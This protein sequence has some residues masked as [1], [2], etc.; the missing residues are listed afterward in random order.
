MTSPPVTRLVGY[1]GADVDEVAAR[2]LAMGID[3]TSSGFVFAYRR[4]AAPWGGSAFTARQVRTGMDPIVTVE[5]QLL[6]MIGSWYRVLELYCEVTIGY[7][8]R[9]TATSGAWS[10]AGASARCRMPR[11]RARWRARSCTSCTPPLTSTRATP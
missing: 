9:S 2:M 1:E 4:P 5:K 3:H 11:C 6:N 8:P 7:H 10:A